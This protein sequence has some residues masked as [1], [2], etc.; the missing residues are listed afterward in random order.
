MLVSNIGKFM[1]L[2]SVHKNFYAN[3]GKQNS[4]KKSNA[5]EADYSKETNLIQKFFLEKSL[6]SNN[7]LNTLV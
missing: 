5:F 2:D 1:T 6:K 3:L 4:Q 7:K